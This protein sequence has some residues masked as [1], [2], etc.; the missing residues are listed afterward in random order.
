DA[1]KRESAEGPSS[2]HA[3]TSLSHE[4]LTKSFYRPAK[5]RVARSVYVSRPS[6]L[7]FGFNR[8]EQRIPEELVNPVLLNVYELNPCCVC[9]V[10]CPC[11]PGI[12]CGKLTCM[13]L[14]HCGLEF[15]GEREYTYNGRFGLFLNRKP[16]EAVHTYHSPMR[17]AY[18][19][20]IGEHTAT[21]EELMPMIVELHERGYQL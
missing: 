1:S 2:K 16:R 4:T 19:V 10:Q 7:G 8:R 6:V 18:S 14:F 12:L 15:P 5:T 17:Y 9:C 20:I 13:G 3:V 11:S 21:E